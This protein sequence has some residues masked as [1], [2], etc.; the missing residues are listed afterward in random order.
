MEVWR[1]EVFGPVLALDS[2]DERRRGAAQGQR[3]PLRP[4]RRR[5]DGRHRPRDP[6]RA[7]AR[8]R[9]GLGQQLSRAER[10]A[11][12]S[13]AARTAASAASSATLG[14]LEF[15]RAQDGL[16]ARGARATAPSWPTIGQA[17]IAHKR[18]ERASRSRRR[19]RGRALA[20][21]ATRSYPGAARRRRAR[22]RAPHAVPARPRPDRPLQGVP[23]PQAQD[24]GL[25]RARGR[26]LPHAADPHA[27]GHAGSR[28][29][30]RARCGLNEDL[31]E[32]IGLGHDL[33]H[34]PFGHIGEAVLDA[35]PAASATASASATTSTRC[36]SSSGSSAT[37]RGLNLTEQVRDGILGHTGP[38]PAPRRSRADRPDRRPR[39]LHQPRHR[40]RPARRACST[41]ADLPRG[42]DR[43]ARRDRLRA[44]RRRSS[45]T[46]SS[47]RRAAGDESSRATRPARRWMRCASSC[48]TA[49]TSP[50]TPSASGRGSSGCCARCSTT[51]PSRAAAA[52]RARAR[53]SH[54]RVVD[55]LAGMTDRFAIRSLAE[56]ELP[57]RYY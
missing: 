21:L 55:Y 28:A 2:F 15:S 32:A 3:D 44:D 43:G 37:A 30:S 47:T 56:L 39:R 24:A 53:P 29:P 26:P 17:V 33:G 35:L 19:A 10:L 38:R 31:T 27:R 22:C 25:H 18:R 14:P 41:A 46:W 9:H 23:A 36:A 45:T 6:L 42:G 50:P 13:A 57:E 40:R 54:E 11:R 1:E 48:S 34:P 7:R 20:P 51:T 12:R 16:R 52:G 4:R 49:S 5:L 8:G